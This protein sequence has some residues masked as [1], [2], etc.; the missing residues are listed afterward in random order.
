M[1]RRMHSSTTTAIEILTID[2]TMPSENPS[3]VAIAFL[4][5]RQP[6]RFHNEASSRTRTK[7]SSTRRGTPTLARAAV[8]GRGCKNWCNVRRI[9]FW[10]RW[11]PQLSDTCCPAALPSPSQSSSSCSRPPEVHRGNCHRSPSCPC[12]SSI[13]LALQ[14]AF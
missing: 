12:H 7:P 13:F 1:L 6:G 5:F 14:D 3:N 11:M 9:T 8:C 10:P 4:P 2:L